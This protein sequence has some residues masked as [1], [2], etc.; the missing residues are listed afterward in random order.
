LDDGRHHIA[1]SIRADVSWTQS[2][3]TY[4]GH[5]TS[6]FAQNSNKENFNGIIMIN[7]QGNGSDGSRFSLSGVIHTTVN[8]NGEVTV[9]F[10]RYSIQC[11]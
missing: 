11:R 8:A 4:V 7:G 6:S 2:G 1:G 9:D 5:T 3:V 10:D